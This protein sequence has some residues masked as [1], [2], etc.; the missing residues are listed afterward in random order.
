MSGWSQRDYLTL[1]L[2]TKLFIR[3]Y[4]AAIES[5]AGV[6]PTD[7]W[8]VKGA[9]ALLAHVGPTARLPRDLDV[10]VA[11]PAVEA[12]LRRS[13]PLWDAEGRPVDILRSELMRFTGTREKPSVHRVLLGVGRDPM[14]ARINVDVLVVPEADAAADRRVT[15][16]GF[17]TAR[18]V[19]PGATFT[20]CLAQKL[21][22][23]TWRRSGNR[24][25][26]R[27]SDLR[28]FLTAAASPAASG[29]GVSALRDDVEIEFAHM[30][31]TAP[32]ELPD[33]PVEWLDHWDVD[34]FQSGLALGPLDTAVAQLALFWQP[35]LS[36]ADPSLCWD[37][38]VWRWKGGPS[39]LANS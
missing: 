34:A 9:T 36:Y 17:P 5:L 39:T 8:H 14:L 25:N 33:P 31:R 11:A 3:T 29:L 20:R 4:A 28:D 16:L 27:W 32:F 37:P 26:T 12:L 30:N 23:Y 35:V 13:S 10:S 2:L 15:P 7:L 21:L 18:T 22:R 1:P 24:V 19:V 6:F 38:E